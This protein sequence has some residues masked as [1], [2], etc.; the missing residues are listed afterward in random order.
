MK[1]RLQELLGKDMG[2]R[3]LLVSWLNQALVEVSKCS[4]SR[5]TN[6]IVEHTLKL[7][8]H[9]KWTPADAS[10]VQVDKLLKSLY[11]S[12]SVH[13]GAHQQSMATVLKGMWHKFR[14]MRKQY[15]KD[16][17]DETGTS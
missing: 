14:L 13:D 5:M 10:L 16:G 12:Y 1:V 15:E 8:Q 11:K 17:T 3:D 9:T 2:V 7:F 4:D 6:S